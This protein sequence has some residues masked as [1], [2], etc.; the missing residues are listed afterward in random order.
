MSIDT[1][2]VPMW[3]QCIP[4]PDEVLKWR[5][6][7]TR[8][9]FIPAVF[10]KRVS[11][12]RIFY[13]P[14]KNRFIVP[15]RCK[16]CIHDRYERCDRNLPSCQYCELS[17]SPCERA[18]PGCE[19]LPG[20]VKI[21][22]GRKRKSDIE[23]PKEAQPLKKAKLSKSIP[24]TMASTMAKAVKG[25]TLNRIKVGTYH[26]HI[27]HP[28]IFR[29][30][31]LSLS[32]DEASQLIKLR[33]PATKFPVQIS[34]GITGGLV[35]DASSGPGTRQL[36][37]NGSGLTATATASTA[38]TNW[39]L[40]KPTDC[41]TW[42]GDQRIMIRPR[43][44]IPWVKDRDDLLSIHNY[45]FGQ[46]AM[47]DESLL[48]EDGC[49]LGEYLDLGGS[50]QVIR[51]WSYEKVPSKKKQSDKP[52]ADVTFQ[53]SNA[54]FPLQEPDMEHP[55]PGVSEFQTQLKKMATEKLRLSDDIIG[56][57]KM[58]CEDKERY[59]PGKH[60]EIS[61][62][63]VGHWHE[64]WICQDPI[65]LIMSRN[66][67]A[68]PWE[69]PEE[70]AY[71][72]LGWFGLVD[73]SAEEKTSLDGMRGTV[74]LRLNFQ[75]LCDPLDNDNAKPDEEI[76]PRFPWWTQQPILLRPIYWGISDEHWRMVALNYRKTYSRIPRHPDKDPETG[77]HEVWPCAWLCP[78]CG[79]INPI[80]IFITT[81]P[82]TCGNCGL[83]G[84][85][86]RRPRYPASKYY[87]ETGLFPLGPIKEDGITV[88]MDSCDKE[89]IPEIRKD[90]DGVFE[91]FQSDTKFQPSAPRTKAGRYLYRSVN[92]PKA[93]DG[94]SPS[95]QE[96][97][98][99]LERFVNRRLHNDLKWPLPGVSGSINS[100]C[101]LAWD[102]KGHRTRLNMQPG[103]TLMVSLGAPMTLYITESAGK[104]PR[105]F[106]MVHG[107]RLFV[108]S[109]KGGLT[110]S[111]KV[112]GESILM[113]AN[114]NS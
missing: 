98:K 68:S 92:E 104:K 60:P 36:S 31:F 41:K 105:K 90:F 79:L 89:L 46:D 63:E 73:I 75:W 106:E 84:V 72:N 16:S 91:S 65:L 113:L 53:G 52:H 9:T 107:S 54:A 3:I 103:C 100:M 110:Y 88:A 59:I 87:I 12:E 45:L 51:K 81:V 101:Y 47:D 55:K 37:G 29:R 7:V 28:T 44:N 70:C 93:L 109:H 22:T 32:I 1:V 95:M 57:L 69:L 5:S 71:V 15:K 96:A 111:S 102:A 35:T 86:E 23:D 78:E 39:K 99:V 108:K 56:K 26:L 34:Q 58:R 8:P 2:A 6:D 38:K 10:D 20:Q 76:Q 85:R 83:A 61:Y 112:T 24:S 40:L 114:L 13:I 66:W 74:T 67:A 50:V 18:A 48:L 94:A 62:P 19:T 97:W 17:G 43:P 4:I 42:H 14:S 33:L 30:V 82:W 11:I 27:S 64:V 21:R 25:D 80:W 77:F 49:W